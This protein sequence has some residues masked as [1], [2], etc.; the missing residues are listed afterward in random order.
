[1]PLLPR[2]ASSRSHIASTPRSR[3]QTREAPRLSPLRTMGANQPQARPRRQVRAPVA[4]CARARHPTSPPPH[5]PTRAHAGTRS[6]PSRP[7]GAAGPPAPSGAEPPLP[8]PGTERC[9]AKRGLPEPRNRGGLLGVGERGP[10]VRLSPPT[11]APRP[12]VKNPRLC[13]P[14]L[15]LLPLPSRSDRA[16]GAPSPL[17][18]PPQPPARYHNSIP[19]FGPREGS[20]NAPRGPL[21]RLPAQPRPRRPRLTRPLHTE[22]TRRERSGDAGITGTS[23]TAPCYRLTKWRRH[24]ARLTRASIPLATGDVILMDGAGITLLRRLAP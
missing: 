19:S 12:V 9:G 13:T 3:P 24:P 1:M 17:P 8:P 15:R 7:R 11:A 2:R 10:S 6:S 23:P 4:R 21:E 20:R 14:R 16:H 5:T 18:V 22:E